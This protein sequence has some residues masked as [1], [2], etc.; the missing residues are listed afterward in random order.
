MRQY[1]QTSVIWL[2]L[3][4]LLG[5]T[6]LASHVLT[7]PVSLFAGLFIAAMKAGLVLWFFMG[8]RHETPMIRLFGTGALFWLAA[9]LLLSFIDYLSRGAV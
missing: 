4:L 2:L 6:V 8:M 7:G 3:A 5:L 1:L 9:L